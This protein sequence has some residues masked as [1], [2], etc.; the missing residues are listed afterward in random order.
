MAMD[1][2]SDIENKYFNRQIAKRKNKVRT[3][4][5]NRMPLVRKARLAVQIQEKATQHKI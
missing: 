3:T 1:D 5:Y 2:L 4:K